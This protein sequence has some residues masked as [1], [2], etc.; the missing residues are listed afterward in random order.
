MQEIWVWPL[1]REDTLEKG[2]TTHF[3]ILAWRIPWTEEPGG[4]QCT[5][6][7]SQTWLSNWHTLTYAHKNK[8]SIQKSSAWARRPSLC[9]PG[10]ALW[11][12]ADRTWASAG[13]CLLL[14]PLCIPLLSPDGLRVSGKQTLHRHFQGSWPDRPDWGLSSLGICS[15][16]PGNRSHCL[17]TDTDSQIF[18][19][20]PHSCPLTKLL[21]SS[22]ASHISLGCC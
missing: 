21:P 9:S 7:Q 20:R 17:W 8:T 13:L 2:M 3:S 18:L 1:G 11:A 12:P 10:V 22:S 19:S 14:P 5:E 16:A 4:L 15:E 6:L